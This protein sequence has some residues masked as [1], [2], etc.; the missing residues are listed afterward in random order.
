MV[1]CPSTS[2]PKKSGTHVGS[3]T[4]QSM[5]AVRGGCVMFAR[6]LYAGCVVVARWLHGGCAVVAWWLQCDCAVIA[7]WLRDSCT[8]V[9]WWFPHPTPL[10]P[11]PT[12]L[13]TRNTRKTRIPLERSSHFTPRYPDTGPGHALSTRSSVSQRYAT[14]AGHSINSCPHYRGW[15][16]TQIGRSVETA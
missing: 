10:L 15:M 3:S 13:P 7:C 2:G 16:R 4:L 9:A 5:H 8:V 6:W 12:T 11:S 14:V 1:H